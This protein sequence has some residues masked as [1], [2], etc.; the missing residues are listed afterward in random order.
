MKKSEKKKK[1]LF[2]DEAYTGLAYGN[3][4][5]DKYVRKLETKLV[6]AGL[7]ILVLI[8]ILKYVFKVI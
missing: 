4:V 2:T 1:K 5:F 7:A 6:R 8:I 3:A